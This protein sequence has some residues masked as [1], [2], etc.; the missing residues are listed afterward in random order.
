MHSDTSTSTGYPQS[1]EYDS[2]HI[3]PQ[4]PL[5]FCGEKAHRAASA[6]RP[7]K[8]ASPEATRSPASQSGVLYSSTST[9]SPLR[10]VS[11][12]SRPLI[13]LP[14]SRVSMPDSDQRDV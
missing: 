11:I 14:F 9:T 4:M 3:S 1:I 2:T 7:V 5:S 8:S 12:H 6:S 13:V 10:S